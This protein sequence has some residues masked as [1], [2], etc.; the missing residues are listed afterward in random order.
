MSVSGENETPADHSRPERTCVGCRQ[1]ADPQTLVRYVCAPDGS[2]LVD[3]R[4][5][6][7]GR[8][9]YTCLK[10]SCVE[11]AVKRGAFSRAFKRPCPVHDAKNL[12]HQIEQAL[13]QRILGLI[14]MARKS[15]K[16]VSGHQSIEASLRHPEE[17]AWLLVADDMAP[18]MSQRL[19][20]QAQRQGVRVL[21]ALSK[22]YLSSALGKGERSALALKKSALAQTL[23]YELRRYKDVIGE[24]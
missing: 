15:G 13:L 16:A 17:L 4:H 1:P 18:S 20:K 9:A 10:R 14:G 6:L 23:E 2:L 3:Y 5:K 11:Q 22:E 7:P 21:A 8:G 19:S 12:V 24:G